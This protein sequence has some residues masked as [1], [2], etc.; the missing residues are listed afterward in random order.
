MLSHLGLAFY[1]EMWFI[2]C[3]RGGGGGEERGGRRGEGG[4]EE[5]EGRKGG[6][7]GEGGEEER[8]GREERGGRRG[9][10]GGTQAF[11]KQQ[12]AKYCKQENLG[13]ED[14]PMR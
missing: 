9:G 4:E 12:L 2:D 13:R 6:R 8:E 10:E 3:G 11:L 1:R 14:V 5:R 7:R